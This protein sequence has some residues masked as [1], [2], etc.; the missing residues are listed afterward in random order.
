MEMIYKNGSASDDKL[1]ALI[2]AASTEVVKK[3][4]SQ[5]NVECVFTSWTLEHIRN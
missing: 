3:A 1:G 4:L 5:G 2:E